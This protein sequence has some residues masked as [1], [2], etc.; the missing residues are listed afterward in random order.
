[1]LIIHDII[2]DGLFW[3]AEDEEQK[4]PGKLVIKNGGEVTISLLGSLEKKLVLPGFPW[5]APVR[6]WPGRGPD[7]HRRSRWLS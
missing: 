3:R 2:K 6:N 7:H 1:M 5:V 4:I